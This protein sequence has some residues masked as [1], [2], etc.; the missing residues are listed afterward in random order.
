MNFPNVWSKVTSIE[1]KRTTRPPLAPPCRPLPLSVSLGNPA[2]LQG[3]VEPILGT[4]VLYGY[5]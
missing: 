5:K 4:S 1:N 3:A 2:A